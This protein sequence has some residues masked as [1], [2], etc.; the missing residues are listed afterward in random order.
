MK[1]QGFRKSSVGLISPAFQSKE[2]NSF[3]RQKKENSDSLI[4]SRNNDIFFDPI[5]QRV[6]DEKEPGVAV[7]SKEKEDTNDKLQAASEEE[8]PVQAKK[9]DVEGIQKSGEEDEEVS[10]K[11]NEEEKVSAAASEEEP[12]Q[13]AGEE[14]E[15]V[16]AKADEEEGVQKAGEEEDTISAKAEDEEK[17]NTVAEEEEPVQ[18]QEEEPVQSVTEEVN[19]QTKEDNNGKDSA[20]QKQANEIEKTLLQEKGKGS[21]LAPAVKEFMEKKFG[22]DFSKVRIHTDQKAQLMNKK[23]RAKAFAHGFDI[24]FN[25]GQYQPETKAGRHLLAHELTH[26]IQQKGNS[27]KPVQPKLNDG[28]DFH[29]TSRFSMNEL[30]EDVYDNYATL[31]NGSNGLSVALL[32]DAL[33][34]LDYRLPKFGTDG[35]FGGETT[36]AVEAFQAD[37]GLAVDGVVGR[38]T[39]Q[40][41]DS[42]DR[43]VDV[44]SPE[45]PVTI[46]STIDL[47]NVIAK[48][49]AVASNSLDPLVMGRIF[50]ETIAVKLQ[51]IDDGVLWHPKIIGLT[52]NYSVQTRLLPGM[53]EITGP[54]GNTTED[55]YC[56]QINDLSNLGVTYGNWYMEDAVLAHERFHASKMRLALIDSA[57]L[58]PLEKAVNDLAFPKSAL[59]M[60][61]FLAEAMVRMDSRFGDAIYEAEINWID[62]FTIL[63]KDD[64][65]VPIGTGPAY[66]ESRKIV[67]PMIRRIRNHAKVNKWTG[68]T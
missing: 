61:E 53:E 65:G 58:K 43:G 4:P 33:I 19:I 8:E 3:F 5:V 12:V 9:D 24:F 16:Q 26:T 57:V 54:G 59:T 21:E 42:L 44:A 56:R 38:N 67:Y 34:G 35:S 68:C 60:N 55:N 50:P 23:I 45:L 27:K 28:H 15:P 29:P 17:I 7:Q 1:R 63:L 66:D 10:A 20:R 22:S 36:R 13:T 41:L 48:A 18:T 32:Q 14:E 11:A 52:G 62:Q 40:Y 46:D 2:G 64:H 6:S 31:K 30:L 49:G 39:I 51:L 47:K 37:M 25:S